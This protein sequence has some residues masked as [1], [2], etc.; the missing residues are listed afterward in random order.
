MSDLSTMA[1]R[2]SLGDYS[3]YLGNACF[4]GTLKGSISSKPE[5][6]VPA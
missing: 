5:A 6:T 2:A 4:A 3:D 1:E